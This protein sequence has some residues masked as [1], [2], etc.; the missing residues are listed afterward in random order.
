MNR[1]T[2]LNLYAYVTNLLTRDI[3][4][5]SPPI[6]SKIIN[7]FWAGFNHDRGTW[8]LEKRDKSCRIRRTSLKLIQMLTETRMIIPSLSRFS[9]AILALWL[10]IRPSIA[11]RIAL[12]FCVSC[13]E[14]S[15]VLP[16]DPGLA[17]AHATKVQGQRL[18]PF[19]CIKVSLKEEYK[20]EP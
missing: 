16:V 5:A 8:Y 6:S 11:A 4:E 12:P 20:K 15:D 19:W 17:L 13:P 1:I 2:I 10:S 3:F 9:T 14:S 7:K 18:V